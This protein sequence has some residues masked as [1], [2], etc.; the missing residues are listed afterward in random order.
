M[1]PRAA[2]QV[3]AGYFGFSAGGSL[4]AG[5]AMVPHTQAAVSLGQ[6]V[7]VQGSLKLLGLAEKRLA[8]PSAVAEPPARLQQ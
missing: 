8:L 5:A 4:A 7:R 3:A 2:V 1:Q 6:L